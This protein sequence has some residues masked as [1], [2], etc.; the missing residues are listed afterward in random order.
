MK[1][2]LRLEIKIGQNFTD[3][4]KHF[5]RSVAQPTSI[6]GTRFAIELDTGSIFGSARRPIVASLKSIE[7]ISVIKANVR[8]I[9]RFA[10]DF[11]TSYISDPNSQTS[12]DFTYRG[13]TNL[14]SRNI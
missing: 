6:V 2:Q 11:Y 5:N 12:G 4:P 3:P 1:A 14:H 10:I 13:V 7:Q 9:I 8:H